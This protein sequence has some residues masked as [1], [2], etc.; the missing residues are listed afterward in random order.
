MGNTNSKH[1][2]KTCQQWEFCYCAALWLFMSQEAKA[3]ML[4]CLMESPSTKTE[5]NTFVVIVI[6]RQM[7]MLKSSCVNRSKSLFSTSVPDTEYLMIRG[8]YSLFSAHCQAAAT[9][10]FHRLSSSSSRPWHDRLHQGWDKDALHH[11]HQKTDY[12]AVSILLH[13]L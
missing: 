5:R 13:N 12:A 11:Q 7:I 1:T 3:N 2:L 8:N 4:W 9:P 10:P 6:K